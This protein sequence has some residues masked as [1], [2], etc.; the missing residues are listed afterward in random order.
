[1]EYPNGVSA[2]W[3]IPL[4]KKSL[5]INSALNDIFYNRQYSGFYVI[6]VVETFACFFNTKV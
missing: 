1:L 3:F 5:N 4:R 6:K 2:A